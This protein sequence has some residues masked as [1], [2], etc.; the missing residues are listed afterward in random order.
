MANTC[1]LYVIKAIKVTKDDVE[2][3]GKDIS[4]VYQSWATLKDLPPP[5]LERYYKVIIHLF[6]SMALARRLLGRLDTCTGSRGEKKGLS[7]AWQSIRPSKRD[8]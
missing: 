2:A 6:E 5:P 8:F 1:I 3:Y 4:A 7:E